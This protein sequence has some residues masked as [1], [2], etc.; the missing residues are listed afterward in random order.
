MLP[1]PVAHLLAGSASWVT[2]PNVRRILSGR[3]VLCVC[4]G[5]GCPVANACHV[6][7]L[8]AWIVVILPLLA[9]SVSVGTSSM[10]LLVLYV[11]LL[12]V[13]SVRVL[14]RN[15]LTAILG[16]ILTPRP[17]WPVLRIAIYATRP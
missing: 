8:A 11:I 1:A 14:T 6:L 2:V 9:T 13:S 15:V 4:L 12:Y 7:F 17:V 3:P 5:S 16:S 10:G